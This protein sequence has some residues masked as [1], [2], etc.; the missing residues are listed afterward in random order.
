MSAVTDRIDIARIVHDRP[1]QLAG[2]TIVATDGEA[3]QVAD[4]PKQDEVDDQHLV[5]H[6]GTKLFGSDVVVETDVISSV[7]A[8]AREVHVD[9]IADWVKSSPKLKHYEAV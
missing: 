8:Q 1:E 5:V 6:V 3:G 7:D 2:F 9:R 4:A